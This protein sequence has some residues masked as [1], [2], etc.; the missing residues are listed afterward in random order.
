MSW[1]KNSMGA[2]G[3]PVVERVD[4]SLNSRLVLLLVFTVFFSWITDVLFNNKIRPLSIS[5][6]TL[7]V[8][9]SIIIYTPSSISRCMCWLSIHISRGVQHIHV[10]QSLNMH[11]GSVF[12]CAHMGKGVWYVYVYQSRYACAGSVF[13]CVYRGRDVYAYL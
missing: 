11:V 12:K 9:S 10:Y 8:T 4:V 3:F 7:S 2:I 1:C 6:Y 5:S 13:I